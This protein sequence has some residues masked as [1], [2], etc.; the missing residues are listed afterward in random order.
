MN[1]NVMMQLTK[2]ETTFE[3]L[4]RCPPSRPDWEWSHPYTVVV[5]DSN[6]EVRRS[7]WQTYDQAVEHLFDSEPKVREAA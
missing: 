2:G 7:Y 6:G 5:T 3:V 1:S 4:Y